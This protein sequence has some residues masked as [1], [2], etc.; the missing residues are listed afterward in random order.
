MWNGTDS[1]IKSLTGH[2]STKHINQESTMDAMDQSLVV[3]KGKNIRRTWH[4]E[5][6]WFS[7]FDVVEALTDSKDP[8]QYI[9]KMRSRDVPLSQ[10]WGT[11][12][13]PVKMLAQDGKQRKINCANTEG[14]F[15]ILQSIPSPKAEPFK[16]WL[17]RVGYDR[18][19]EID[20]PELAQKRMKQLY[21]E[22][23]YPEDC[24][25][26]GYAESNNGPARI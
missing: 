14:I 2:L 9:K 7:V 4:N 11:I 12:C 26:N 21:R 3:F 8:K 19:K 20:N 10:K 13:T 5:E 18:V 22:K 23:G 1:R 17:A 16:L 15:R 6:W 24:T 25:S